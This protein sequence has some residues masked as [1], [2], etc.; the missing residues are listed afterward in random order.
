MRSIA[1]QVGLFLI[2]SRFLP[3][4]RSTPPSHL[5]QQK[6]PITR[7]TKLSTSLLPR[8][9]QTLSSP[10]GVQNSNCCSSGVP[11]QRRG[12]MAS[13]TPPSGKLALICTGLCGCCLTCSTLPLSCHMVSITR[14]WCSCRQGIEEGDRNKCILSLATTRP[15]SRSNTLAQ[16]SLLRS[17]LL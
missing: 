2:L 13:R 3:I 8:F 15:L 17:T 7:R 6:Y 12:L 14:C 9:P 1:R 4:L 11:T 16:L 10:P 5:R